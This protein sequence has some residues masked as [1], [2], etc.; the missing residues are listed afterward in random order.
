[1]S[2]HFLEHPEKLIQQDVGKKSLLSS[3]TFRTKHDFSNVTV[4]CASVRHLTFP[5][6]WD[7]LWYFRSI[8]FLH[9]FVHGVYMKLDSIFFSSP[10]I[11][12][13]S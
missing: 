4:F 10:K 7:D 1:M 11:I 13:V 3:E 6:I 5:P 12:C 9:I 8:F 2:S